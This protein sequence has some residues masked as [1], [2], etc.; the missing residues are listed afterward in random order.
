MLSIITTGLPFAAILATAAHASPVVTAAPSAEPA[1]RGTETPS[2]SGRPSAE[3]GP[4]ARRG[5]AA[6]IELFLGGA[7][8]FSAIQFDRALVARGGGHRLCQLA[9]AQVHAGAHIQ[10]SELTRR[11]A[12][13]QT[14]RSRRGRPHA[15][16]RAAVNRC[17]SR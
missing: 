13:V 3:S 17:P 4:P 2:S 12:P 5:Q 14:H 15:G 6:H 1:P 9:D 10:A 11:R 16:I 7:S 8:V